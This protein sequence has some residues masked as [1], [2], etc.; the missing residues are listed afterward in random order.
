MIAEGVN[1]ELAGEDDAAALVAR[2]RAIVLRTYE[3]EQ[4]RTACRFFERAL[5][6]DRGSVDAMA[7]LGTVLAHM[8]GI[9]SSTDALADERRAGE[10]LR[11]ARLAAPGHSQANAG[12]GVLLRFQGRTA[13]AIEILRLATEIEPGNPQALNQ[14]GIAYMYSGQPAQALPYIERAIE[15]TTNGPAVKDY[16]WGIASC[17]QLLGHPREA[18]ASFL[19]ARARNP[20]LWYV[21]FRLAAVFSQLGELDEAHRSLDAGRSIANCTTLADFTTL[22]A[23][24]SMPQ[25]QRPDYIALCE[26]TVYAGLRKAGMPD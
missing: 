17:Y 11:Q 3:P 20:M 7:A 12:M 5:T 26:P 1:A 16:D 18:L 24:R 23:Y 22:A 19:K 14:L 15:I 2:G 10:L 13:E 9:R 21:H 25:A 4:L 6:L 8:V